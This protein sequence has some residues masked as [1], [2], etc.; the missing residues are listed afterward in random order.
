M[1]CLGEVMYRVSVSFAKFGVKRRWV[2]Q[3]VLKTRQAANLPAVPKWENESSG[4]ENAS[5][6]AIGTQDPLRLGN[7]SEGE[8]RFRRNR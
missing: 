5:D 6:S 8:I 3:F 1:F 7:Q 4:S 2:S